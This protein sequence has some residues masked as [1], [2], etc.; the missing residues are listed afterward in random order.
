MTELPLRVTY[1]NV[2]P[3]SNVGDSIRRKAAKLHELC[4]RISDIEVAVELPHR[5][6]LNGRHFRVRILMSVPGEKL[7]VNRNPTALARHES[8]DAALADAFRAA[9]REVS[10]YLS[11]KRALRHED[12]PATAT[13]TGSDG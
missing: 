5:H 11:Q 1:R 13:N 10:D 4:P 2:T 7:V 12:T 3:Q 9:R 6:H 8:L